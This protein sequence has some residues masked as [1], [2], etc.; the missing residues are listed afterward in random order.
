MKKNRKPYSAMSP[1]ELSEATRAFRREFVPTKPL[2]AKMRATLNRAKRGR[3]RVGRGAKAVLVSVER[4]LLSAADAYAR[5]NK[6][7]RSELIAEGL[8]NLLKAG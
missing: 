6:L 5:K 7:S 3:P 2:S 8:R 4:G 1:A